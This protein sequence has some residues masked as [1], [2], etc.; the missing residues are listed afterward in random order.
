MRRF[1]GRASGCLQQVLEDPAAHLRGGLT[2]ESN[3]EYLFRRFDPGQQ[4]E[5]TLAQQLGLAG[6]CGRLDD[7]RVP[8]IQRLL[9]R[10][11]IIVAIQTHGD[12]SWRCNSLIRH[13][14]SRSQ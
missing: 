5:K 11:P 13:K 12:R 7:K 9:P 6:A 1:G 14:V 10:S 4:S 8:Q 3:R 2:R